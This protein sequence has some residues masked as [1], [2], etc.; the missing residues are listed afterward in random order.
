MAEPPNKTTILIPSQTVSSSAAVAASTSGSHQT[1]A[2]PSKQRQKRRRKPAKK[3][4]QNESNTNDNTSQVQNV[5]DAASLKAPQ[6]IKG[7]A[8][9]NNPPEKQP[10]QNN[11]TKKKK[12]K[13]KTYPWR[14]H[15]PSGT[16]DPISL[17]P[18]TQLPYPPF[19][20]NISEPYTTIPTWPPNT[21]K[22]PIG[23]QNGQD[24]GRKH[25]GKDDKDLERKRQEEVLMQQWGTLALDTQ[26]AQDRSQTNNKSEPAETETITPL[27]N[28][29]RPVHLFDGRVLAYYLISQLQFIDP[30][31]RRDLTREELVNLDQ[32]LARHQLR[33]EME[34][35][36]DPDVGNRNKRQS[37]RRKKKTHMTVVEAYDAKGISVSTAG[38]GG[39][40]AAGRAEIL[41]QQAQVLLNALFRGGVAADESGGG[42]NNND[43]DTG[44]SSVR[45]NVGDGRQQTQ[46]EAPNRFAMQYAASN[47]DGGDTETMTRASQAPLDATAD[48]WTQNGNDVGVYISQGGGMILIDTDENPGLRAG[49]NEIPD[50]EEQVTTNTTTTRQQP[51]DRSSGL[52]N[53]TTWTTGEIRERY[54]GQARTRASQFPSLALSMSNSAS[55]QALQNPRSSVPSNAAKNG[56]TSSQV[57]SVASKTGPSKS[58]SK[59]GNLVKKTDPKVLEKQRKAREEAKQ[60]AE[61][62]NLAY[63]EETPKVTIPSV[64]NSEPSEGQL[65]RNKNLA[66]ALGVRPSTARQHISGWA[67]P[68]NI[69]ISLDEF[70]NELNQAQYPDS[71]IIKARER[72]GELLK[73][74]RKWNKFLEDDRAASCPLKAMDKPTRIFVHEYS[75]FWKLHTQSF[76]PEPRRYIHC[77]KLLETSS[78]SPLLSDAVRTWRGPAPVVPPTNKTSSAIP[79]QQTAGQVTMSVV[80]DNQEDEYQAHLKLAHR[81]QER[82]PLQLTPRTVTEVDIMEP[83]G[84]LFGIDSTYRPTAPDGVSGP[85]SATQEPAPR[86]AP[87]LEERE[88]PRMQLEARTK[89]LELPPFQPASKFDPSEM[90]R[91]IEKRDRYEE[92]KRKE[93]RKKEES[94]LA[95]AFASDDEDEDSGSESD[96]WDVGEAL[97]EGSDEE[98]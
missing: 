87:L 90:H 57:T 58:L 39:Q 98:E 51:H 69:E 92:E 1:A 46:D 19:A 41:Q 76:D 4:K 8:A 25:A 21:N 3:K 68:T 45:N 30:L 62:A 32:Y 47:V 75:D 2:A 42:D 13:K 14:K 85:A 36:E 38:V 43:D 61:I 73:L 7:N 11:R 28:A 60:R 83:P 82:T 56:S 49:L 20:L 65:Q 31:N 77:V 37:R 59:I 23:K 95:Y 27:E 22:K 24:D 94:I 26:A 66:S 86:F 74:E 44:G 17:D 64:A 50:F 84:A 18:L 81:D 12:R 52:S 29:K 16:V 15:I 10:T 54:G 89:P 63:F 48:P 71:L 9:K 33:I 72:M 96:D 55:Y 5:D 40:S 35:E 67:R 91:Q 53:N 79:T 97:Y 34:Q 80:P 88:R 78:P 70:G 93:Q 6:T